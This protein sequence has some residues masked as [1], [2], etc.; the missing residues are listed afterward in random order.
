M[1]LKSFETTQSAIARHKLAV[2]PPDVVIGIA[3]N[4][5]QTLGSERG[6]Q[7]IE[8]GYRRA[9]ECLAGLAPQAGH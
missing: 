5:C 2:Y 1:A 9:E 3:N 8:L 4:V 7:M 6:A